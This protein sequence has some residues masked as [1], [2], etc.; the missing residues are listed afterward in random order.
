MAWGDLQRTDGCFTYICT[1]DGMKGVIIIDAPNE[2]A[3]ADEYRNRTGRSPD[4]VTR[5]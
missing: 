4:S 5:R 1:E 2:S 3:A